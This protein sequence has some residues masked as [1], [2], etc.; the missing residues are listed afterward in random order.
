MKTFSI[1]CVAFLLAA[2]LFAACGPAVSTPPAPPAKGTPVV[3]KEGWEQKW[4]K[5]LAEG[6]K[7]G[8]VNVYTSW[9]PKTRAELTQAFK[10]KY[11]INLEFSP[12]SGTSEI[13]SKVLAENR[14]GLYM[15]DVFGTGVVIINAK[16]ENMLGPIEPLL[17]L[18]EVRNPSAWLGGSLPFVDKDTTAYS[19][20]GVL[21]RNIVINTDLV[22]EGEITSYKDLLKP[23]YKGKIV[24]HDPS[25]AGAS[26]SLV[27]N[28]G[29]NVWGEAQTIDFLTRLLKEQGVVIQR[30]YRTNMESVARGKYAV[31]IA[32]DTALLAEF[33]ALG[34]PVK[35]AM[36]EE[37]NVI[38][39]AAGGLA[40]PPKSPHPNASVV[41]I[42]WLLTKEGQSIFAA[43]MGNPSRRLDASAEGVNP[44]FIPAPGKKYYRDDLEEVSALKGKWMEI[45]KKIIAEAAR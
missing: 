45:S 33:I 40:V 8:V 23:Q 4:E 27:T 5:A 32:P 30:D 2:F 14:S 10:E 18:P 36:V 16:R 41:F 35:A 39:A 24:S 1:L 25:V 38:A 3:A 26:I 7:E 19:M 28:L 21:L 22:K 31:N 17:V 42:N 44:I 20:I 6:K 11:G 13:V 15:A 29:T 9:K 43:T 34:A 12:F 37:D